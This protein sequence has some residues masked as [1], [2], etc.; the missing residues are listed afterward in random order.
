MRPIEWVDLIL[1]RHG[2]EKPDGR[3]L[4]QYRLTDKEYSDLT[5]LLK[6]SEILG[7]TNITKM[8][9]WD[10]A[11]VI[12]ASEWWRREYAGQWGWDGI[13]NSLGIDYNELTTG[14]RNDLIEMGLHR[15]RRDVRVHNG[16]RKF[17]GTVATEG[18]LPLH[19][20]SDSGGWLRGVLQ[21]VLKKHV[22]RDI[23]ISVLIEN[24]SDLIPTSYRSTEIAQILAD[25][26]ETVIS[27]RKEHELMDKEAPLEWLDNNRP[28]WRELFPLPIDDA[29]GKS[30][31]SDLVDTVSK[32]RTDEHERNPF[33]VERFLIRAESAAPELVAQI[34][35]PTFVSFDSLEVDIS[36]TNFP[37][38]FNLEVSE[39]N[40]ETWPWCRGILTTYR[41]KQA[42][43][44]SGRALKLSGID[45][46]RELRLRFKSM[47]ETVLEVDLVNGSNLDID[48]PW[49]FRN[50]DEKWM[51]HGVASQSIENEFAMVFIPSNYSYE[52]LDDDTYITEYGRFLSG[53]ILKVSGTIRCLSED[54]KYKISAGIEESVVQYHLSGKRF[55]YGTIP[56]EVYL[57][58]PHLIE[59][60]SI[61]GFS[62]VNRGDR[63]LAKPVGVDS[64]WKPLSQYTS[65][66]YEKI[67]RAS[68]RERV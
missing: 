62:S 2:L 47:G 32:A 30:L 6:S 51:L 65:G 16:T 58:V 38:S 64:Q 66:Y 28:N 15:W 1:K 48:L 40:G 24:Y 8:L 29:A 60:N 17:L 19:Q 46:T 43:K 54:V 23:A 33:E 22:S 18:G 36:D 44:L 42:L 25:I 20:L 59:K 31:L 37:S 34:E 27:L 5:E 45:A 67:G 61:T 68:C 52:P 56:G 13:F 57:G 4:F 12:Y 9:F 55:S 49:L 53:C 50:I 3:Q 41:G 10:A 14:R 35:M 7:I 26:A 63:L 39:P 21:P 11:F